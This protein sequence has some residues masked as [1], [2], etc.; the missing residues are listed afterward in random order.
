MC[1]RICAA[2]S[3][4]RYDTACTTDACECVQTVQ[5]ALELL[6]EAKE[7][8]DKVIGKQK[9]YYAN[10]DL[11]PTADDSELR[12][13]DDRIKAGDARLKEVQAKVKTLETSACMHTTASN[14]SVTE[15]KSLSGTMSTAQIA[16]R[17]ARLEQEVG[18]RLHGHAHIAE[19]DC[20]R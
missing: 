5:R 16:H 13:L 3:T 4:S 20:T 6:A 8:S 17:I 14:R 19:R 1:T 7:I 9:I 12:A 15:M 10:Q 2:S 18:R 11:L